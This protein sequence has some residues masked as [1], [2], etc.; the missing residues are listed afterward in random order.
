V[1]NTV[2]DTVLSKLLVAILLLVP[3]SISSG[4]SNEINKQQHEIDTKKI[5]YAEAI[6]Y[7]KFEGFLRPFPYDNESRQLKTIL[8]W[9]KLNE[10][11]WVAL[12]KDAIDFNE[13]NVSVDLF[14]SAELSKSVIL[15]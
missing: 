15:K 6:Y 14:T 9:L 3:L 11:G 4:Y 12:E 5:I 10:D 8:R 7:K 13:M 1:V 2:F